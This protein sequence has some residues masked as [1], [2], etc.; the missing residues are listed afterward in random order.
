VERV[1]AVER[2][3]RP[4]RVERFERPARPAARVP[5]DPFFDKPYEA[6]TGAEPPAWEK[7]KPAAGAIGKSLSPY[8]KPKR[9]VA[10]LFGAKQA[11][12]ETADS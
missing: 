9:Q 5:S 2:A 1:E 10:A 6:P 4:E 8:I 3:P 11:A 12:P 7:A